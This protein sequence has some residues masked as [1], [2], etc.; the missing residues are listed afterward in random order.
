MDL[1][2][3]REHARAELEHKLAVKGFEASLIAPVLDQLID[4]RLLDESRFAESFVASR[5]RRGQG[6]VRIAGDLRQR[7]VDTALIDTALA[8]AQIDWAEVARQVRAGKFGTQL[9]ADYR[10]WARQARFLQYRGFTM[11]QIHA[12]L[13][14]TPD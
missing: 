3:R 12:A 9:P 14:E 11:D 4:E 1:L 5:A 10:E 8:G 6:T 13:D 2:A 7:G